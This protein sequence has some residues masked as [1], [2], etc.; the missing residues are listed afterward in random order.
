MAETRQKQR[1]ESCG[2]N[3]IRSLQKYVPISLE[4]I[5]ERDPANSDVNLA[6]AL[7]ENR[8]TYNLRTRSVSSIE[9]VRQIP[10]FVRAEKLPTPQLE[11]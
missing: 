6:K 10:Y 5:D 1:I 7:E 8:K 3:F 2:R 9:N 4:E 11:K